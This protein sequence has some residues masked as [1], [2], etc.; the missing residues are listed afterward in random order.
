V[1]ILVVG[2]GSIGER[3]IRN[4][5]TIGER[6]IIACDINPSKLKALKHKYP[7]IQTYNKIKE[8]FSK[9]VD[10]TL[11]C[12]PPA[13]HIPIALEA[14]GKGSH[15]FIEKP[16]SSSMSGVDELIKV[17]NRKNLILMVG[18]NL[19]FHPNVQHLKY[20]IDSNVLGDILS[21]R[22]EFGQYLPDWHPWEDYRQMYVARKEM[23]GGI[24][25]DAIHELD[26]ISWFLGDV[27]EV[28]CFAGKLSTLDID[29]EDTA[30]ILLRFK[31]G[32]IGEIHLDM[33]QRAYRR[34]C[35]VMGE[36]GT[37]LWDFNE[38]TVSY[39]SSK[40]KQWHVCKEENFDVNNTYIA[41][42][43]HFLECIKYNKPP[44]SDGLNGKKTLMLALAARKSAEEGVKVRIRHDNSDNPS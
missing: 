34:G 31:N 32:A 27:K 40:D 13:Y 3:H 44:I 16:L 17:V 22:A 10:A 42:I 24:I 1:R 20:L 6:E 28:F 37:A 19:R 30:E 38:K 25:L 8:A 23:G 11:V 5:I 43:K 4:L 2:C 14:A 26:Y 12:T 33:V 18:Y 39:Y 21:I 29:V 7:D 41:E 9:Y 15:L 36:K 35:Q